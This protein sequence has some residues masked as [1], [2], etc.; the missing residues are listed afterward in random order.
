MSG[1][2]PVR[3]TNAT[4]VTESGGSW[5][6]D[7]SR[8]A[9][10]QLHNGLISLMVVKTSGEATPVL[11]R[12][13]PAAPANPTRIPE[14]SPDGRWIA[15]FGRPSDGPARGTWTLISPDGKT[16]RSLEQV[17][18]GEPAV[19]SLTFSGDSQRLYGIRA[20]PDHNYLF[21]IDVNSLQEKI[22]GDVGRDFTPRTYLSP[23]V[24]LSLSS[25]GAHVLFPSFRNSSSLWMLEGFD[26][27]GW[28]MEL[29]EMLPW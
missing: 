2:P 25:D 22:I 28:G 1:G 24:R 13:E 26:P 16:V 21:S 8:F 20:E 10:M 15:I 18:G 27:P 23:G 5:S 11:L 6:P 7:G 29:R 3:L 17:N 9:Y 12:E 14:W 4:G 19:L